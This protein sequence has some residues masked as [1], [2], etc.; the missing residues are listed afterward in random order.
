MRDITAV[1]TECYMRMLV[2]DRPGVI[3][4]IA[5]VL[6]ENAVSLD[7]VVQKG[8]QD[9]LAEIIWVTHPAP[10]ASFRAAL[11]RIAELPVVHEICSVIRV[12]R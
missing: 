8:A 1:R 7:S 4:A 5:G 3:S 10:E 12:V 9:N 11:A 6:G 2:T